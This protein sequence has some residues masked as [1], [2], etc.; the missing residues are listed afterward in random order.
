MLELLKQCL[1]DCVINKG[2]RPVVDE[3]NSRV[4]HIDC[5]TVV[6]GELGASIEREAVLAQ[7]DKLLG[8]ALNLRKQ[9]IPAKASDIYL[10]MVGPK[11]GACN[12]EWLALAAEIERD[13]RLARKH[14]WLP[15][16][17]GA[18]FKGF[19]EGTFLA[20]PWETNMGNTDAL[21]LLT[22]EIEMPP[23]WEEVLLDPEL[24]GTDLVQKL[25]DLEH[26]VSR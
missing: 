17:V 8:E 22:N 26:G 11:G 23:G 24:G 10:F 25:L 18:N 13:D 4:V 19:L 5:Y 15:D 20:T 9:S 1:F 14:V 2:L 3:G 16:S 7:V 12:P 6:L 21:A